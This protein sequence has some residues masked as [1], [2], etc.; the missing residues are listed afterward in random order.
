VSATRRTWNTIPDTNHQES[1]AMSIADPNEVH[2]YLRACQNQENLTELQGL[3]TERIAL[4]EQA[5]QQGVITQPFVQTLDH[6]AGVHQMPMVGPSPATGGSITTAQQAYINEDNL[7]RQVEEGRVPN[8]QPAIAVVEG[9]TGSMPEAVKG[10]ALGG[11]APTSPP[12]VSEQHERKQQGQQQGPQPQ[13]GQ[14]QGQQPQQAPQATAPG[15]PAGVGPGPGVATPTE[16]G[17]S[18]EEVN[19]GKTEAPTPKER[20]ALPEGTKERK[21]R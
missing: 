14:Q 2:A 15:S 10:E 18:P 8:V 17:K 6:T 13:Q 7:R 3:L 16:G 9:P 4:F 20:G 11:G 12:S 19:P 21:G 5:P 1:S